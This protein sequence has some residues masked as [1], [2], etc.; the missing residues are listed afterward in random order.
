MVINTR[1]ISFSSQL[2]IFFLIP[3]YFCSKI[4]WSLNLRCLRH[5]VFL[6]RRLRSMIFKISTRCMRSI[7]PSSS[8]WLAHLRLP[9]PFGEGIAE[10]IFLSF[11]LAVLPSRFRS[12]CS[13][14]WQS[15]AYRLLKSLPNFLR[16]LIA[17]LVRA[18]EE[19]LSFGLGEFRHLVLVKRNKQNPGTFL[20][21]PRPWRHVIED[22]PYRD[23]KWREQFFRF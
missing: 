16:H 8:I 9:K 7:A 10:P 5:S 21:S 14:F 11:S 6:T 1:E 13:R 2:R 15:L 19:C 18:R 22:V 12:L 3:L 17:F 20:V 4:S 23:E